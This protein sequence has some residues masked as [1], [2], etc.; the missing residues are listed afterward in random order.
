MLLVLFTMGKIKNESAEEVLKDFKVRGR[1]G[2]A[3][4]RLPGLA[5]I[6]KVPARPGWEVYLLRLLCSKSWR[7]KENLQVM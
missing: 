7:V 5:D 4:I 3:K 6:D 2:A 1:W